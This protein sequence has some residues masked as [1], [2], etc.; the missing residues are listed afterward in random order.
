MRRKLFVAALL[1]AG[2][3][4][5]DAATNPIQRDFVY[6]ADEDQRFDVYARPGVQG[7][8]VILLVHGG[9]WARG[10]INSQLGAAPDYTAAVD[11]RLQVWLS[12]SSR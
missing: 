11:A 4:V 3:A 8:P 10:E 12:S 6:G 5:A 1:A 2:F 9:G 7:A